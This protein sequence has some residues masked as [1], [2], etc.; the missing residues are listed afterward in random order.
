MIRDASSPRNCTLYIDQ[1][2][3]NRTEVMPR[4]LRVGQAEDTF[5]WLVSQDLGMRSSVLSGADRG[6]VPTL[7]DVAARVADITA[8]REAEGMAASVQEARGQEAAASI[9]AV[10]AALLGQ[11]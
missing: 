9:Y 4:Q 1:G 11:V 10:V 3:A 7:E 2:S 5:Q 8:K 6:K